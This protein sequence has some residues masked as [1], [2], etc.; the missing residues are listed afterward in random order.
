MR[1]AST[2]FHFRTFPANI[3]SGG[4]GPNG[5]SL[6]TLRDLFAVF[7]TRGDGFSPTPSLPL[8]LILPP[9]FSRHLRF[10]CPPARFKTFWS[11]FFLSPLESFPHSC[12]SCVRDIPHPSLGKISSDAT[13]AVSESLIQGQDPQLPESLQH[14]TCATSVEFATPV[15]FQVLQHRE[16]NRAS[17]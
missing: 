6:P 1:F 4:F 15:C 16:Q 3:V 17:S 7:W 10:P 12:A 2:S 5:R 14:S 11:I 13:A 8:S 9:H